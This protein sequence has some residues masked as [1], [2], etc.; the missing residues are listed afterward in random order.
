M[1]APLLDEIVDDGVIS[2]RRMSERLGMPLAELARIARLH[3][4]TL[5]EPQ[6]PPAQRNLGQIARILAKA[7]VLSGDPGRAVVWFRY[8][9]ISGLDN[10]TAEELVA[11]GHAEAVMDHLLDLEDGI[12]A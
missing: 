2:P 5:G 9:R 6:S 7:A 8:Q 3:R 10:R 4:N 1:L 12:Y 11:E